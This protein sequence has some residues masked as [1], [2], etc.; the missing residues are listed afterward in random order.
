MVVNG[1][2]YSQLCVLRIP[3]ERD[4]HQKSQWVKARIP[5]NRRRYGGKDEEDRR[6]RE[7]LW[8]GTYLV[9]FDSGYFLVGRNDVADFL[10]P[11]LE[12]AL[13]NGL[14]HLWHLDGLI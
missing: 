12:R 14:G 7:S 2:I 9:G 4:R 3:D 6:H 11:R 13:R 5:K 1:R 10:L 8:Y